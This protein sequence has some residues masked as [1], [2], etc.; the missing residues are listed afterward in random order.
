VHRPTGYTGLARF[1]CGNCSTGRVGIAVPLQTPIRKVLGSDTGYSDISHDTLQSL[2][3]NARIVSRFAQTSSLKTFSK[4]IIHSIHTQ[5]IVS[6]L[7]N[8][9]VLNSIEIGALISEIK[10]ENGTDAQYG[11]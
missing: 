2:Q 10:S 1:R 5:Y 8:H 3:V 7:K 11:K 9:S 6:L 4:F